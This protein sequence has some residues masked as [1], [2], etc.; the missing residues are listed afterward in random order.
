MLIVFALPTC[1]NLFNKKKPSSSINTLMSF[2]L[3][4]R[5]DAAFKLSHTQEG[6]RE[7]EK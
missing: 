1:V 3:S 2:F 4:R 5:G 7:R 6:E